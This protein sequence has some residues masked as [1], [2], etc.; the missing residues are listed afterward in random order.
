MVARLDLWF[1]FVRDHE[2]H[3]STHVSNRV[4]EGGLE[5]VV[6]Q[7]WCLRWLLC[8]S[9]CTPR[10]QLVLHEGPFFLPMRDL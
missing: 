3:N 5:G 10:C 4:W 8:I 1:S 6:S 9:S 7:I 2:E